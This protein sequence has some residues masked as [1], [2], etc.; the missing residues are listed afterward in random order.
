MSDVLAERAASRCRAA[1]L[2]DIEVSAWE[3]RAVSRV[4]AQL[5]QQALDDLRTAHNAPAKAIISDR[6][7]AKVLL[8]CREVKLGTARLGLE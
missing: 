3:F 2:A 4:L 6:F 7:C 8:F 5:M 1:G